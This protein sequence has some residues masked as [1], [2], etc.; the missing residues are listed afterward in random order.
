M[1]PLRTA[2]VPAL[3]AVPGLT[4][5]FERRLG[6]PGWESRAA[7]RARVS[8]ALAGVGEL[9]LLKQVHGC[10][11]LA[12]PW[13]GL[14]E[15][16]AAVSDRPGLVVGI[17][18]ADCL[19]I[20]IVDPTRCSA[21]AVHAGWRGTA[22]G[23]TGRAVEAL[24]AQGSRA[25]DLIAALG[26]GIGVCC[27]EVGEELRGVFG[28]DSQVVFRPGPRGKPHLDIRLASVRQLRRAG[29]AADR[30][31]H[32]DECTYCRPDLYH[33]FRREGQGAGRMLNYVG[34]RK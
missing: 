5:G 24:I 1:N 15:A 12:A 18:T 16:D 11:V 13:A 22:A 17:E 25:L 28:E 21:A 3:G 20:L 23:I 9:L 27:Y 19:P 26:P 30:I 33:S 31:H 4:H 29:L 14:P 7:G 10:T 34:W 32:V 6:P 2:S 8:A